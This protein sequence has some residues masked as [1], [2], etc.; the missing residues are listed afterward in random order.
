MLNTLGQNFPTI[1]AGP[2]CAVDAHHRERSYSA[3]EMLQTT[4]IQMLADSTGYAAQRSHWEPLIS[5]G[6]GQFGLRDG[7]EFDCAQGRRRA[8]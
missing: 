8:S 2:S 7:R 1:D 6:R 4:G 5:K 3:L